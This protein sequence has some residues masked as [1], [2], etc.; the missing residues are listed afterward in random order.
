MRISSFINFTVGS[1]QILICS[2]NFVIY[3]VEVSAVIEN[4]YT[5]LMGFF[6]LSIAFAVLA[7]WKEAKL[8]VREMLQL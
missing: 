2:K 6:F 5:L 4:I 1:A 7:N 8:D 3:G